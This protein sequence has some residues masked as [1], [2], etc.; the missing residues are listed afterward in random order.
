MRAEIC[1]A[2]V[3]CERKLGGIAAEFLG[4]LG[5]LFD[6]GY[7]SLTLW[8]LQRL[9]GRLEEGLVR[10][11]A[12][13]LWDAIVV[14]AREE[15]GSERRPDRGSVLELLEKRR[16]LDLKTLA[17]ESVVLRLLSNWCNEVVPGV[18]STKPP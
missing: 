1:W 6:L 4:D 14:F 9:D 11:E 2:N 10:G 8:R 12:A 5:K 16:V 7:L 3:P 15:T 17:V 18:V 13:V